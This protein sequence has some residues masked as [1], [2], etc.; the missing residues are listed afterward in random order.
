MFFG[1]GRS[2]IKDDDRAIP[3]RGE[4]RILIL[5]YSMRSP[6]KLFSNRALCSVWLNLFER[7]LRI[8]GNQVIKKRKT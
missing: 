6:L 8:G 1:R 4:K 7:A 3:E 5:K 2:K